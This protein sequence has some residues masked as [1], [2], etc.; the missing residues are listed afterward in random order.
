MILSSSSELRW[1]LPQAMA[2]HAG[3]AAEQTLGQLDARL[4]QADEQHRQAFLDDDVAGDVE[5]ERR[6]ADAGPGGDDDQL[7]V[8]KARRSGCRDRGSRSGCR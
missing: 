4:L 1:P 2:V 6:L 7:V 8:L 5:G 3:L